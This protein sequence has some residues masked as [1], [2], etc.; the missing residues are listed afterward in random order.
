MRVLKM[1]QKCVYVDRD[2]S[3]YFFPQRRRKGA[4]SR[5]LYIPDLI[6][7]SITYYTE[8]D[9]TLLSVRI[10]LKNVRL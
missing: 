8:V 7:R 10:I 6:S 2:V 3:T 1:R 4:F 9:D 5:I